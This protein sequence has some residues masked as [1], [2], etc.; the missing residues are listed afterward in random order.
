MMIP[1]HSGKRLESLT[2][3]ELCTVLQMRVDDLKQNWVKPGYTQ[4]QRS[5]KC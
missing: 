1:E 4:P 3:D 2:H 5:S